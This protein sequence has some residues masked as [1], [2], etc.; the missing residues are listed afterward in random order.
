MCRCLWKPRLGRASAGSAGLQ[1]HSDLQRW[2]T[3]QVLGGGAA[4]HD[5]Q[6]HTQQVAERDSCRPRRGS[7]RS[8]M[9]PPC[10]ACTSLSLHGPG[11]AARRPPSVPGVVPHVACHAASPLCCWKGFRVF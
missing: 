8:T 3:E 10:C 6:S 7:L 9:A 4:A 2:Q 1:G 11:A 5:C